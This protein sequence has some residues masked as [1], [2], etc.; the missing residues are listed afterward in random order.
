MCNMKRLFFI[1]ASNHGKSMFM[2]SF[3][4]MALKRSFSFKA[5]FCTLFALMVQYQVVWAATPLAKLN[6][7]AETVRDGTQGMAYG[8]AAMAA[9]GIGV[10]AFFGKFQWKWVFAF[11]AGVGT[12]AAVPLIID[13][14]RGFF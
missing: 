9:L 8:I 7:F 14:I 1:F 13:F 3:Y 11:I 5:L 2:R 6:P 10:M 12:I 4:L